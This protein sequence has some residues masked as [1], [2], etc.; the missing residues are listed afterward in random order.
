MTAAVAPVHVA[1]DEFV[2][3]A[4][5]MPDRLVVCR[6]REPLCEEQLQEHV[7]QL[8][9]TRVEP[10]A[11]DVRVVTPV[12]EVADSTAL[13]L[14]PL[15]P[16]TDGAF[17]AEPPSRFVLSCL[18]ADPSGGGVSTFVS[19]DTVVDRAPDRVLDGLRHGVFRFLRTYDGDLSTAF[20]GPVLDADAR[21]APRIRWRADH[22]YRPAVVDARGT[23]AAEA[24]DWL[25]EFLRDAEPAAYALRTGELVVVPNGRVVHGRTA[26]TAGSRRAVLRAWIY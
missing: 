26:L 4:Q 2:E 18:R 1:P 5:A 21:G 3:R 16:H 15:A 12:P 17:L 20:E 9:S 13:S 10:A 14:D 6:F 7:A 8:S 23:A 11:V 24:V 22:L 25:Y 19:A